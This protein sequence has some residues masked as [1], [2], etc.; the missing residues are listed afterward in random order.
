MHDNSNSKEEAKYIDNLVVGFWAKGQGSNQGN[1]NSSQ[2]NQ[3]WNYYEDN[4]Y[5]RYGYR[6]KSR[7]TDS[8]WVRKEEY[9]DKSGL[10][11]LLMN[12]DAYPSNLMMEDMFAKE[13]KWV[14]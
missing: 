9:K 8:D 13:F 2:G 14:K 1:W 11:V 4:Y 12:R 7:G 10:Y 5:N 6:D 3:V